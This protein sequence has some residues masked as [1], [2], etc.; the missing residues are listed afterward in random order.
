[1]SKNSEVSTFTVF[2]YKQKGHVL[3]CDYNGDSII[4]GHLIGLEAEDGS[5]NMRYHQINADGELMTG[6]CLSTP[7]IMLNG[8]IKLHEKWQWTSGDLSKGNSILE[9]V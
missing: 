7:E 9:E 6:I 1:M 4:A 3:T 8:K 2:R 5:I